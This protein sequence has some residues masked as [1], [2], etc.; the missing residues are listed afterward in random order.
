MHATLGDID[1]DGKIDILVTDLKYGS[2]YRNIGAGIFKDVT[3]SSGVASSLKGKGGWAAALTDFDNDGDLDLFSAN[4]TAE[5]LILQPA[6]LLQNDGKGRFEN[7]NKTSG[8][9]F[10]KKHSGRGGAVLD[11]D[12]DGDL[13]I[14][15]SHVEPGSPATLLENRT[16]NQNHWVGLQLKASDG[17]SLAGT[18]AILT[19][20]DKQ[21]IRIYQPSTGYL[22]YS[23]PRLHVRL[24]AEP[25]IKEIKIEWTD[26]TTQILKNVKSDRY[27]SVVKKTGK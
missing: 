1:N 15:V 19:Y 5:E 27:I 13:D 21:Q 23:D 16:N 26:G 3:Q 6:L 2:L 11:F 24:G 8:S 20:G 18:K 7:A 14:I 9:Y 17:V 4:G 10:Q 22:S 12:N 25:Q